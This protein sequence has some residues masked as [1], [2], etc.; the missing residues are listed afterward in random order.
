[1]TPV[2]WGTWGHK[3]PHLPKAVHTN[4]TKWSTLLQ[5]IERSRAVPA[6]NTDVQRFCLVVGMI[7]RDLSILATMEG[8]SILPEGVPEFMAKTCL[9]TSQRATCLA[10]CS[11]AF[12]GPAVAVPAVPQ[13]R[14]GKG[15]ATLPSA[16]SAAAAPRNEVGTDG[17][18]EMTPVVQRSTRA[19]ARKT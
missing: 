6:T 8:S 18:G 14:K 5:W 12:T 9:Q 11:A 7:L 1:M 17:G 13:G 4:K 2:F 3:S 15:R 10:A 16:G 19:A